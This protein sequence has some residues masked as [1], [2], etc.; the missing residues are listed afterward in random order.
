MPEIYGG[1]LPGEVW[2]PLKL[3]SYDEPQRLN[4]GGEHGYHLA[5]T[6]PF[7]VRSIT[8]KR[9]NF[10]TAEHETGRGYVELGDWAWGA[11]FVRL[12]PPMPDGVSSEREREL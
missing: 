10:V 9:V 5:S 6:E 4:N 12:W 7:I 3:A 11:H 8:P 2:M 1:P